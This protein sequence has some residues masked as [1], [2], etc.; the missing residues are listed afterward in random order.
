[1]FY[2][3]KKIKWL[4]NIYIICPSSLNIFPTFILMAVLEMKE[5]LRRP[6]LPEY[7]GYFAY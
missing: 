6:I 7:K 3:I 4:E 2:S 5:H 1:M